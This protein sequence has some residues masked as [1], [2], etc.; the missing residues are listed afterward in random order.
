MKKFISL[1]LCAVMLLGAAGLGTG[2]YALNSAPAADESENAG[3]YRFAD[4]LINGLVGGIASIVRD[5]GWAKLGKEDS[6][7]F[8]PGSAQFDSTLGSSWQLG[9]ASA[10]LQTGKELDGNHYVGGSLSVSRKVATDIR[11]DQRVRTVAMSAGDG[12]VVFASLDAYGLANGDVREIRNRLSAFCKDKNIVSINVSSLHQHSCV[13]T[14]G[15]NGDIVKAFFTAPLKNIFGIKL[16]SGKNPEY[17]ENL[18]NTVV[19]SIKSAVNSMKAGKLYYG[20]VDASAYI[21]DKRDPQVFDK[22]LNRLRFAPDDGSAQTWLVNSAIHC[23]GNGAAGTVVT[24]DYPY[25][26]EKYIKENYNAN[27]IIIQ[28]AEL[29]ITSMSDKVKADP[30]NVEKYGDRYATLMEYGKTLGALLGTIQPANETEVAPLLNAIHKR[31]YVPIENNILILAGKCGL[32]SNTVVKTGFMKYSVATEIG[33]IEIGTSIAVAV[34]P[35]ELAPE[36]AFGSATTAAESWTGEEW[37]YP[38][39]VAYARNRKLLVFGITNDQIGY[40]LTDNSWHS[41]LCEN[42]EI[43]ATGSKAGSTIFSEYTSLLS[44]VKRAS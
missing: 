35:G 29:A 42:E 32:L 12:T 26:M 9:Y 19:N 13:D 39:M 25:Y 27:F 28:G 20:T 18:Y 31:I 21:R 30:V 10:S 3:L 4:K 33:Y 1:F 41:I 37:N 11:D 15:M 5:P 43:V 22:N 6:T 2:A 16:E 14:F 36:I 17:M 23:V 40:I 44:E 38:S 24:G 8:M 7:G 34:I